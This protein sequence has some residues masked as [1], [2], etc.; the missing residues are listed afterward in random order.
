EL[1]DPGVVDDPERNGTRL[2][3]H[4]VGRKNARPV[5]DGGGAALKVPAG[6][7]GVLVRQ[8]I[9]GVDLP[10]IR[11]AAANDVGRDAVEDAVEIVLRRKRELRIPAEAR[12]LVVELRLRPLQGEHVVVVLFALPIANVDRGERSRVIDPLQL[13][14]VGDPP[15]RGEP[16]VYDRFASQEG[17]AGIRVQQVR[18]VHEGS[19]LLGVSTVRRRPWSRRLDEAVTPVV[20]AGSVVAELALRTAEL[21][22]W[23]ERPPLP[24]IEIKV[25]NGISEAVLR[26]NIDHAGSPQSVL[27][28]KRPGYQ[29][30]VVRKPRGKNLGESVDTLGQRDSVEPIL[31]IGMVAAHMKLPEGVLRDAGSLE[32]HVV[33]R[34]VLPARQ[35]LHILLGETVRARARR[36]VHIV[37]GALEP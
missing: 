9:R 13:E 35:L 29:A 4:G 33:K 12:Q 36:R 30:E 6:P 28:R 21:Q 32:D 1:R 17:E 10:A 5:L 20:R 22:R 11:K 16:E 23:R 26:P 31:E 25:G 27:S 24:A 34:G 8:V 14:R 7:D 3:P 19:S 15:R 2:A 18:Q 37:P